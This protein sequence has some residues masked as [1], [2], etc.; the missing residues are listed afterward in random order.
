[1]STLRTWTRISRIV[2][3]SSSPGVARATAARKAAATT[4]RSA[5][6]S[7][8]KSALRC[9]LVMS[10][11]PDPGLRHLHPRL[12]LQDIEQD[13]HALAGGDA[14]LEDG[15]QAA[16]W[17]VGDAHGGAGRQRARGDDAVEVLAAAEEVDHRV[18][19]AR[20]LAAED[21]Q[22][23]DSWRARD[24]VE[25]RLLGAHEDV[26]GEERPHVR[27]G[28]RPGPSPQQREIGLQPLLHQADPRHRLAV[29]VR[30]DDAPGVRLGGWF[31]R[32]GSARRARRLSAP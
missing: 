28:R 8:V 24:A 7:R 19:E 14:A 9:R 32:H 29:A 11:E 22:A 31:D 4:A 16:P 23:A 18:V 17:P 12:A 20:R 5:S 13:E 1:M 6:W 27:A 3:Q 26:A 21:D 15:G 2:S 10:V 30:R 25:V